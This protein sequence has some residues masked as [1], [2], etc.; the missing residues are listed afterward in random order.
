MLLARRLSSSGEGCK[1]YIIAPGRP[2]TASELGLS[3]WVRNRA[4]GDVGTV[5]EGHADAIERFLIAALDDPPAARVEGI[6]IHGLPVENH[7]GFK[8]HITI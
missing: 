8:Q 1:A 7:A 2:K 5:V 3:G 4:N 6:D